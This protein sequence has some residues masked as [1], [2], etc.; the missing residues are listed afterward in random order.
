M[1]PSPVPNTADAVC[2]AGIPLPP[3]GSRLQLPPSTTRR[4]AAR[5]ASTPPC[6]LIL[7][8]GEPA[9]PVPRRTGN[10]MLA[11]RGAA[12]GMALA[13][14]ARRASS[15]PC[16]SSP[17]LP[18]PVTPPAACR[19][20]TRSHSTRSIY[21]GVTTRRSAFHFLYL[22]AGSSVKGWHLSSSP[23]ADLVTARIPG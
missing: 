6:G 13:P 7:D 8:R 14:R 22:S 19:S 18:G 11:G 15:G 21:C 1:T 20:D 5:A 2:Q 9:V 4:E 16:P 17:R 12:V 23:T 3:P 10:G